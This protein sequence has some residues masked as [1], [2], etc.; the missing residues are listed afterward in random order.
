MG[1]FW[2]KWG[3]TALPTALQ[4]QTVRKAP[5]LK[6]K[7]IPWLQRAPVW[8]KTQGPHFKPK[9]SPL[10]C[11]DHARSM[12]MVL[13]AKVR[14]VGSLNDGEWDRLIQAASLEMVP[15][16]KGKPGLPSRIHPP[17]GPENTPAPG[18][19]SAQ[20]I[21]LCA[22]RCPAGWKPCWLPPGELRRGGGQK[23]ASQAFLLHSRG[24]A[25]LPPCL[26]PAI[27]YFRLAKSGLLL[28]C[29]QPPA[30]PRP[31]PASGNPQHPQSPDGSGQVGW[32]K[33]V[34]LLGHHP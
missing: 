27:N 26:S 23:Q 11:Q 6:R 3:D 22:T 1:N 20:T 14:G 31:G 33:P 34:S 17:L 28:S 13:P 24:H 10:P 12:S 21:S 30:R 19:F 9:H 7:H 29:L 5:S 8:R 15:T 32:R 18:M 16:S 25:L 4:P 2:V